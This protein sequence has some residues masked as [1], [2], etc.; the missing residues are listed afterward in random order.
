MYCGFKLDAKLKCPHCSAEM[1]PGSKF[2]SA[3][4]KPATDSNK[5]TA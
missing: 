3:C 2:C 5:P 1:I 4:G